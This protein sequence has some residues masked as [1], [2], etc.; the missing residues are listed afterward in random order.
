MATDGEKKTTNNNFGDRSLE[1]RCAIVTGST[2]GIGEGIAE[3]L[4]K[5]GC[6]LVISGSRPAENAAPQLQ[7]LQQQYGVKVR[8]HSL[9]IFD[10]CTQVVIFLSS[11]ISHVVQDATRIHKHEGHL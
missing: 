2:S 5:K 9:F 4:A 8:H 6:S 11:Y 1:G 3:V 7:R 10:L